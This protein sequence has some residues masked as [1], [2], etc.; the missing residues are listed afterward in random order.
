MITFPRY[1]ARASGTFGHHTSATRPKVS[2]QSPFCQITRDYVLSVRLACEIFGA[3]TKVSV[4][5]FLTSHF[6]VLTLSNISMSGVVVASIIDRQKGCLGFSKRHQS[7]IV[8]GRLETNKSQAVQ[9]QSIK[10]V[11]RL[12]IW[13]QCHTEATARAGVVRDGDVEDDD[14]W[15]DKRGTWYIYYQC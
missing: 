5:E 15:S 7:I 14:G 3:K 12:I 4:T 13:R 6:F 10:H 1:T 8:R 9:R 11:I 2:T